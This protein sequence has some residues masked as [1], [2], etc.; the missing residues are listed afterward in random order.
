MLFAISPHPWQDGSPELDAHRARGK[1]KPSLG[2]GETNGRGER[3]S[4]WWQ[5][6]QVE[7][8]EIM[9]GF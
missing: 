2:V 8:A 1:E 5:V 7:R 9:A 6:A 3:M 4:G